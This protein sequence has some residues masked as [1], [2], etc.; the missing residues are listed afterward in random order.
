MAAD[1]VVVPSGTRCG[2]VPQR[3]SLDLNADADEDVARCRDEEGA[4]G[5]VGAVRQGGEHPPDEA[6]GGVRVADGRHGAVCPRLILG[7]RYICR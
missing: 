4:P 7:D 3:H 6:G 1:E 5:P 2:L